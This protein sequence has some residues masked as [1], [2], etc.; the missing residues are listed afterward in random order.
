MARTFSIWKDNEC[1][2]YLHRSDTG[3][4]LLWVTGHPCEE[5]YNDIAVVINRLKSLKK[6]KKNVPDGLIETLSKEA[7]R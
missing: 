1:D 4:W 3:G 6:G 2:V 7:A 5:L